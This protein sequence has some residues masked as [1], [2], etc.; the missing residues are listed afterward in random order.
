MEG[1]K[2]TFDWVN[3]EG[4]ALTHNFDNSSPPPLKS[5]T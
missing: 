5:V 2:H 1:G 3:L 4:V